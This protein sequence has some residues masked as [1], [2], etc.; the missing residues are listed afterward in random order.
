MS[1]FKFLFFVFVLITTFN[2]SAEPK[3]NA[4]TAILMDYDSEEILFELD[5]DH[6]IYQLQ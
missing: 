3:I 2:V 6:Q 1:K 4:R 5:P